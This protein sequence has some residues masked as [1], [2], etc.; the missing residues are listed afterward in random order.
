MALR[1]YER[2]FI[3]RFVPKAK[4]MDSLIVW[5]D[6][7]IARLSTGLVPR[8]APEEAFQNLKQGYE[9][10]KQN[11]PMKN[12]VVTQDEWDQV[13]K[14]KKIQIYQ[15]MNAIGHALM[16]LDFPN[17]RA[18]KT[19]LWIFVALFVGAVIAY[20]YAHQAGTAPASQGMFR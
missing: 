5:V 17:M 7:L 3:V 1:I 19:M 8:S 20:V 2:L 12:G 9:Q 18:G 6:G 15:E 4:D 13:P 10:E 16:G 11:V 14:S